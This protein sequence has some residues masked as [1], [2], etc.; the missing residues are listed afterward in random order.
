MSTLKRNVVFVLVYF[1]ATAAYL[2]F[3]P[4]ATENVSDLA[5][6]LI[7]VV[8]LAGLIWANARSFPSLRHWA[9]RLAARGAVTAVLTAG[10]VLATYAYSWHVRPALGLQCKSNAIANNSVE[11]IGASRAE[12]SR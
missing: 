9:T 7:P 4:I 6:V 10:L 8:G 1:A 11:D 12:S 2:W 5:G 3:D